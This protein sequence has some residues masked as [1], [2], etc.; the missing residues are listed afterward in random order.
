LTAD[1]TNTARVFT[2]SQGALTVRSFR[3]LDWAN[4]QNIVATDTSSNVVFSVHF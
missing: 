1:G 4:V 3:R 2:G